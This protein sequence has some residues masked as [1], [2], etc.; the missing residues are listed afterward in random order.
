MGARE[1]ILLMAT[2][3]LHV[4]FGGLF[5]LFFTFQVMAVFQGS[6]DTV[7]PMKVGAF[8]IALNICLDPVLI[9]G[10]LGAP[11][12]GV[13]GAAIATLISRGI[14][15]ILFVR[16]LLRGQH[17]VR[18]CLEN[19]RP[20][21]AVM[22]R[23]LLVGVPGAIQ[24]MVRSSSMVVM[25]GL[26]ALFGP[27]TIAT[28]GIGNRLFG[29]FLLPGFGFGAAASTMV[30]QNLGARNP[31]RAEKSALLIVAYYFSLAIVFAIPLFIFSGTV[32]RL[33]TTDGPTIVLLSEFIKYLSVGA[34]FISPGM[35]FSQSLQGAGATIYPMM[36]V[37]AA[38]YGVQIPLAWFL[39]VHLHMEATGLW[40]ANLAS[41]FANAVIMSVVFLRGRWKKKKV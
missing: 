32:A 8:S 31:A 38:L 20:D 41:G 30:G 37:I 21:F 6:G 11:R 34:L 18:I 17:S 3:Y 16:L 12:M 15:V 28:L 22:K 13:M 27:A 19:M 35:M 5:F 26:A 29:M 40:I 4:L 14:G 9:F 7:T 23:I 25:T 10:L 33:F 1:H 39:G 24:M 36:G 2:S